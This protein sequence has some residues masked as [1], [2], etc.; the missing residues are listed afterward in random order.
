MSL[1]SVYEFYSLYKKKTICSRDS[2]S[3]GQS[4]SCLTTEETLK[5]TSRM[6][7]EA[8]TSLSPAQQSSGHPSVSTLADPGGISFYRIWLLQNAVFPGSEASSESHSML[9]HLSYITWS[10]PAF[11][12]CVH[13]SYQTHEGGVQGTSHILSVTQSLV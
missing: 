5:G 1:S 4:E 13:Q 9:L 12:I 7:L 8:A 3:P 2:R 10:L 11:T 6:A